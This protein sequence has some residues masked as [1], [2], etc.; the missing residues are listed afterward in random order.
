MT[1]DETRDKLT[2][3]LIEMTPNA[4]FCCSGAASKHEGHDWNPPCLTVSSAREVAEAIISEFGIW[5]G[6]TNDAVARI[7]KL[8]S[9]ALADADGWERTAPLT[10]REHFVHVGNARTLREL[11]AALGE[12]SARADA[13]DAEYDRCLE[14]TVGPL[15]R[16]LAD[17]EADRDEYRRRLDATA[18]ETDEPLESVDVPPTHGQVQPHDAEGDSK[19]SVTAAAQSHHVL[20]MADTVATIWVR[21]NGSDYQLVLDEVKDRIPMPMADLATML[22]ELAS[23]CDRR[24]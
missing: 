4:P 7:P 3:L 10:E 1:R 14:H 22:R 13:I 20:T 16:A 21:S 8:I 9:D 17:A 6:P 12:E 11:A 19:I 5:T 18:D 23:E 2:R 24:A 15:R